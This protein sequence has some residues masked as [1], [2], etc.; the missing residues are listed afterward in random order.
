MDRL[1]D[2]HVEFLRQ[3][4]ELPHKIHESNLPKPDLDQMVKEGLLIQYNKPEGTRYCISKAGAS[5]ARSYGPSKE[6]IEIAID[7]VISRGYEREAAESI[8][9]KEG[10]EKILKSK[11]EFAKEE[12][13]TGQKEVTVPLNAQG[14]TGMTFKKS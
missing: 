12:L 5:V 6:L 7:Y 14:G 1:E 10:A 11:A 2:K 8:V 3:C 9:A 13:G 4:L